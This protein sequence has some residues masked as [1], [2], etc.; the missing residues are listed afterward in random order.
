MIRY[1]IESRTR[2]YAK[3]AMAFCHLQNIYQTNTGGNYWILLQ[4]Q[5]W[6]LQKTAFENIVCKKAEATRKVK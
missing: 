6:M 1:S 4:N 5:D 2:K 3:G